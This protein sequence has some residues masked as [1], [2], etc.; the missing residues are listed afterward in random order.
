MA[1]LSARTKKYLR[2]ALS[3]ILVTGMVLVTGFLSF[4]G[5]LLLNDSIYL[6]IAAFL[7]AGGIEGEVY[8]KNIDKSLLKILSGEYLEDILIGQKLAKLTEDIDED[9]PH[10]CEFLNDYCKQLEYTQELEESE[11]EDN[12]KHQ[13][14]LKKAKSRLKWMRKHFKD[15]MLD[16]YKSSEKRA[17][18]DQLESL[19]QAQKPAFQ[20]EIRRK[21]WLGRLSWILNLGAG[22]SCGLVGL[23]VAQSSILAMTAYFGIAL[24]GAAL[25]A[26]VFGLAA[27][28]A[29]GYTLLVHNT[30]SDMIHNDTLQ[31]WYREVLKFFSHK[32]TN[33]REGL[34]IVG[35]ALL[36]TTVVG[37][38][39]FATAA[40]AGTWWYAAKAGAQMIPWVSNFAGHLRTAAVSIMGVTSFAFNIVNSLES[41]KEL[42][43]ISA[44]EIGQRIKL[45][46]EEYRQAENT[47]QFWNPARILIQAISFPFKLA[48]FLA[49][50]FAMSIMADRLAGVPPLI[51]AGLGAAS[52]GLTDFNS[53][54][55]DDHLPAAK[56]GPEKTE[57]HEEAKSPHSHTH[58]HAHGHTHSHAHSHAHSPTQTASMTPH[59]PTE[60]KPHHHKHQHH[61]HDHSHADIAG[62]FLKVVLLPLYFLAAAWDYSFSQKNED[63]EKRLTFKQAFKKA[64]FGRLPKKAAITKPPVPSIKWLLLELQYLIQTDFIKANKHYELEKDNQ[65]SSVDLQIIQRLKTGL[66]TSIQQRRIS[67]KA[68]ASTQIPAPA[69][70]NTAP[71][72]E[73]SEE[74]RK[75]SARKNS[76]LTATATE[77]AGEA[78]ESAALSESSSEPAAST[79]MLDTDSFEKD[80]KIDSCRFFSK[81][82]SLSDTGRK[83]CLEMIEKANSSEY[84]HPIPAL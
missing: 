8:A 58:G 70:P 30:I 75:N 66:L 13:E 69:V 77:T 22:I 60:A 53:I 31:E 43:K 5:M 1:P 37:L 51:T 82:S 61:D 71:Q 24:S 12:D 44:R 20:K 27:V 64:F 14:K 80:G 76:N 21:I 6:A 16:R 54:F 36:V 41:V 42:A 7:L 83:F 55:P 15:F 47:W 67:S 52:E 65:Q 62:N 23:E 4:S 84:L 72:A 3:G 34:K 81:Y 57:A 10:A 19:L 46:V 79:L 78:S 39:V 18:Y 48:S 2:Y 63:L 50:L 68:P 40:T 17:F 45:R 29:L 11:D 74:G 25:T 28:G 33:L 49:H 35:G 56:Q 32:P 73:P 26:S 59:S 9:H 38:G